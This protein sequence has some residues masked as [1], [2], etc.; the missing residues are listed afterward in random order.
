MERRINGSRNFAEMFGGIPPSRQAADLAR[1]AILLGED[2]AVLTQQAGIAA[3]ADG[4]SKVGFFGKAEQHLDTL[5]IVVTSIE[6][7]KARRELLR[8][9]NKVRNF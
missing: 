1:K 2:P 6:S 7:E 8:R 5:R 3:Q 9:A 4:R